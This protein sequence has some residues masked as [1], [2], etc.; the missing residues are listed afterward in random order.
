MPRVGDD[1]YLKRAEVARAADRTNAA[2]AATSSFV[3]PEPHSTKTKLRR[4]PAAAAPPRR[5]ERVAPLTDRAHVGAA[6]ARAAMD[7]EEERDSSPSHFEI[8]PAR[9]IVPPTSS[10]SQAA[11]LDRV[12]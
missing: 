12:C 8:C 3:R 11:H 7:K 1:P 2:A 5:P 10:D 4:R 9:P 6:L